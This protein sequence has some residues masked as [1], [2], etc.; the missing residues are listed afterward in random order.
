MRST[1]TTLAEA[2]ALMRP[3]GGKYRARRTWVEEIGRWFASQR[4]A[5]AAVAL[6]RR[7]QAG[8]VANVRYQ[9]AYPLRVNGGLICTYVA[10][11][12]YDEAVPGR[13]YSEKIVADAK[14]FPTPAYRI[15]KRLMLAVY[16]IPI[17]EL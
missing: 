6:R 5:D 14:G 16:G 13:G 10:D 8:E 7:E 1:P 2:A 9:V 17:V 12:V 15:K 11:F 3:A 4:E